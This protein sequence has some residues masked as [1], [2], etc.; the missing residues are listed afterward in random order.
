M[1]S[2]EDNP[3]YL[4]TGPTASLHRA[5]LHIH[6]QKL[7]FGVLEKMRAVSSVAASLSY[8]NQVGNRIVGFS[9]TA[10]CNQFSFFYG[11]FSHLCGSQTHGF[12]WLD[13]IQ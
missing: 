5:K 6:S 4:G 1:Q 12:K 3:K 9:N 8:K 10:E 11:S 7:G 13:P 2:S